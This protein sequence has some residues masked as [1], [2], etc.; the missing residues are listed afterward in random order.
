MLKQ[1][2]NDFNHF[3]VKTNHLATFHQYLYNKYHL[4]LNCLYSWYPAKY[5]QE[6]A[7]T[8]FNDDNL[9]LSLRIK[10]WP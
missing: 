1:N 2:R 4:H 6:F 3:K 10:Y 5:Y 9:L 8:I 7:D